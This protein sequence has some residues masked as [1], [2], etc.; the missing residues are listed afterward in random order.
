MS[1]ALEFILEFIIQTLLEWGLMGDWFSDKDNRRL[2]RIEKIVAKECKY[3]QAQ[4]G[5]TGKEARYITKSI[6][7]VIDGHIKTIHLDNNVEGQFVTSKNEQGTFFM[8]PDG[9]MERVEYKGH[10]FGNNWFN[11]YAN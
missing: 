8:N 7:T 11:Q 9:H 10:V 6:N 1:A 3:V 5:C 2:K 4:L